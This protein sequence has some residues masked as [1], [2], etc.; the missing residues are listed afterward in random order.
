MNGTMVIVLKS[1]QKSLSILNIGTVT[2]AV[3]SY[4]LYA[5]SIV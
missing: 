5:F 3:V 1:R 4:L 2:Y